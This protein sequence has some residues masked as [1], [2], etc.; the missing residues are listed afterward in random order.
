[1]GSASHACSSRSNLH[2]WVEDLIVALF[3]DRLRLRVQLF[4]KIHGYSLAAEEQQTHLL[5]LLRRLPRCIVAEKQGQPRY[6]A[7][8]ATLLR[9]G[10]VPFVTCQCSSLTSSERFTLYT[11]SIS[12]LRRS[13]RIIR[14]RL[15]IW[16]MTP[17]LLLHQR[18]WAKLRPFD[19]TDG[20]ARKTTN[21]S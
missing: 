19:S 17:R 15:H 11:C 10:V 7:G 8:T 20:K 16:L 6:E 13:K 2:L 3:Q 18:S 21:N 12:A 5:P 4:Q 14:S 1:M 9:A